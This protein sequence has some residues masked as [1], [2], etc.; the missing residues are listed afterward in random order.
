LKDC[1]ENLKGQV[2]KLRRREKIRKKK[3][4]DAKLDWPHASLY[5]GGSPEEREQIT[6]SYALSEECEN[7]SWLMRAT[8]SSIIFFNNIY[9]Y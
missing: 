2:H 7:Q 8:H 1:F 5:H 6:M 3:A 9:I 4:T